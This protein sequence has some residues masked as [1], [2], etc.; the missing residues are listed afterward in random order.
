M[1]VNYVEN[2]RYTG[3]SPYRNKTLAT[4]NIIYDT[5]AYNRNYYNEISNDKN[6]KIH[7]FD[8]ESRWKSSCDLTAIELEK[9]KKKEK[10][11]S[12]KKSNDISIFFIYLFNFKY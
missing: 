9:I 12:L 7:Y 2:I 8:N 1:D 5:N 11:T 10:L 4:K 3:F 6:T